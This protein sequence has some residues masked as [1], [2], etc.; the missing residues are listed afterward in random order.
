VELKMKNVKCPSCNTRVSLKWLMFGLKYSDYECPNC[1]TILHWTKNRS[2]VIL[3]ISVTFSSAV[4]LT[5]YFELT[6]SFVIPLL[7]SIALISV[8]F[9]PKQ[10]EIRS[11][12][13]RY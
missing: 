7:I 3:I 1:H 6:Y 10:F 2:Y 12:P 9:F 8:L 13:D 11:D 4:F 5:K